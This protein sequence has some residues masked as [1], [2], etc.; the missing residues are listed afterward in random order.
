M[1][2]MVNTI[3]ATNET[4]A[5]FKLGKAAA[6]LSHSFVRNSNT[7][8]GIRDTAIVLSLSIEAKEDLDDSLS[9]SFFLAFREDVDDGFGMDKREV[10]LPHAFL[11]LK[12]KS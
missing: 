5:I 9:A 10:V 8:G 6:I 12:Q 7:G 2:P 4:K 3:P 1:A 11:T